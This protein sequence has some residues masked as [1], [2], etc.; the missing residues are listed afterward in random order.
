MKNMK[1][2]TALIATALLTGVAA[3]TTVSQSDFEGMSFSDQP[4]TG[5][6]IWNDLITE[7]VAVA[8]VFYGELFD[9]TFEDAQERDGNDYI[10]ARHDGIY[11]AGIVSV[12]PRQDGQNVTRWVPYVSVDD[13]DAAVKRSLA[14][15][16][17]VAVDSRD[18]SLGQ[19]AAII[20][21]EGAVIGLAN[22][23]I[24]DPDDKTTRA[25]PGRV[26][27]SELLSRDPVAASA[28]YK[29]LVG[30]DIEV[31]NRRG[32][33][34][35]FL[36]NNGVNRAGILAR[37]GDDIDPVWLTF[38]GVSDPRAAAERAKQLGGT[39]LVPPSPELRDGTM[40]VVTDPAGAI[41]VL[42]KTPM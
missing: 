14:A 2:K 13:V 12:E 28:F 42:Q 7:D 29:L 8:R 31:V 4:L 6:V 34:Y 9:W 36:S 16:A 10:V 21:P 18:V 19:V 35:T 24:G 22:S 41:L 30:Y 37:P 40:A 3:C 25:A 17:T 20:D 39:V 1:L 33:E 5:K 11:V 15:G 27:W 26:V 38:F 23:E 32:G